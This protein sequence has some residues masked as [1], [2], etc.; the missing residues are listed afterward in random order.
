MRGGWRLANGTLSGSIPRLCPLK[1]RCQSGWRVETARAPLERTPWRCRWP[2]V[3][4]A[5]PVRRIPAAGWSL[6]RS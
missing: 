5:K 4:P 6:F 2:G 3:Q 1:V